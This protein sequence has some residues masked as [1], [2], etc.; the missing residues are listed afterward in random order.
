MADTQKWLP[1]LIRR[2]ENPRPGDVGSDVF[3]RD[4]VAVEIAFHA[5]KRPGINVELV[6]D[7]SGFVVT[8]V[9]FHGEALTAQAV[10]RVRLAPIMRAAVAAAA[11]WDSQ[12]PGLGGEVPSLVPSV[13]G[14]DGGWT[15]VARKKLAPPAKGPDRN[16]AKFYKDIAD[17]WRE[18]TRRSM[19]PTQEIARRRG[20]PPNRVSQWAHQARELGFLE[21]A[22]R[23]R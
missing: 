1:T 17:E 3:W 10:Q 16:P 8:G 15:G 18:F 2:L 5:A 12:N 7:D 6:R 14:S 20:V 4:R 21:P 22:P 23:S 9:S 11:E 19:S 13:D